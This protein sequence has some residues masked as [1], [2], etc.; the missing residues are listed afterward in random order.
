MKNYYVFRNRRD[1]R[2]VLVERKGIFVFAVLL[3]SIVLMSILALAVGSTYVRF[4]DVVKVFFIQ[5]ASDYYF[6]IM[7]LRFP[8]II[9]ALLAG[10]ALGVSGALLQGM[11]RNPLA[12][13]D[14]AGITHGAAFGAILFLSLFAGKVSIH[15]QPI[16]AIISAAIVMTII[17]ALSYKKGLVPTRF[18][19]IG[20]GL[21]MFMSSLTTFLIVFSDQYSAKQAYIWLT[22]SIYGSTYHHIWLLLPWV[23]V[24][25]PLS[26]FLVR[27]IGIQELGDDWSQSLGVPVQKHRLLLIAI[28][29]ALGGAAISVIG[30]LAFVGLVAPHIARKL[31]GR[32]Y[33]VLIPVSA[34]IG[35]MIVLL[36]DIVGRTLFLPNDVPA[37]IFTA[38]IGAPFFIYLL[39]RGRKR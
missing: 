27:S 5:E 11:I 32:N 12:S 3:I 18:I 20:I 6:I 7:Q 13:P 29:V 34:L 37:G 30:A 39:Y 23:F 1:T 33:M 8:R 9:V 25:I 22:G 19:L 21:T 31:I 4:I 38:G 14:I 17:Y 26:M 36:S 28:S 24:L 2:S 35:A 10:A 16:A 15:L